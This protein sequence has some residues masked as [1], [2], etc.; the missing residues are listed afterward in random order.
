MA[1]FLDEIKS[2][3]GQDSS[4]D[5]HWAGGSLNEAIKLA[6]QGWPEGMQLAS[7]KAQA[8]ST[9]LVQQLG[10]ITEHELQY[11]CC[12]AAFDVGAIVQG[13]PEAWVRPE[14][15]QVKKEIRLLTNLSASSGVGTHALQTR[16]IAVAALA[17]ALQAKGHPVTIDV[18]WECGNGNAGW[19][20]GIKCP[21]SDESCYI[22][23]LD[24]N[25]PVMDMDKVIFAMAHPAMLRRLLFAE[26]DQ[27]K[28]CRL[29]RLNSGRV[30]EET[31]PS[32]SPLANPSLYMGSAHLEQ[33]NRWQDGG[34]SWIMQ[35]YLKQTQEQ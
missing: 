3:P 14:P 19:G 26:S 23:V 16:G 6:E 1:A 18:G 5:N 11:D 32:T 4:D 21:D 9:R 15:Q 10:I 2:L 17:L 7:A 22:R 31:L 28:V 30:I 34:E 13:V 27:N 12:G 8:I 35:E 25:Y 33:A 29:R 24:A 20:T